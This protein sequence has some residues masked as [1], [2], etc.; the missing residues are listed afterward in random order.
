VLRLLF[1]SSG[2][3]GLNVNAAMGQKPIEVAIVGGGCAGIAA[4]FE[5]SRPKHQGKY[6]V[7]VYQQ[8]WRLGGKGASGRGPAG[9]IEEHGIHVWMGFYENSFRL[10]R[11][12]YSELNRNP[13]TCRFADWRDAFSPEPLVGAM[14]RSCRGTWV[15]WLAYFPPAPG[16]PGDMP[17]TDAVELAEYLVRIVGLIQALLISAQD[18]R[19]LPA[20][21]R[22]QVSGDRTS[23]ESVL[24]MLPSA[25]E[26]VRQ[27]KRV[28]AFGL[29]ATTSGLIEAVN[30]VEVMVKRVPGY[31]G[32]LGLRLV[33]TISESV[34]AQLHS[35]V[36]IDDEARRVWQMVDLALAVVFGIFRYRL[37][38]HPRG[39]DA[40]DDVDLVQ[41]LRLNGASEISLNSTIIRALY[42]L[43]FAYEQGDP[44]IPRLAAG[45]A[46]R[47]ALR[48]LFTYRG[49]MVW[50]LNAGMGDVVFAPFYQLLKRRG[51]TFQFFHRLRNVKLRINTGARERPYIESLEFDEQA[52]V[53]NGNDYQPLIDVR[54]VPSWPAKPDYAQLIDGEKLKDECWEFESHWE[55]RRIRAKTLRVMED[56]DCV[57]LAVGLGAIPYVCRELVEH[58][59]RWRAMITHCKTAATQAF[60][61]W[62][63][64]AIEDLAAFGTQTTITGFLQPFETCADMRQMITQENWTIRPLSAAYFCGVLPDQQLPPDPDDPQFLEKARQQVRRNAVRFLSRDLVH[65]WPAVHGEHGFR[66]NLLV[67]PLAVNEDGG[68]SDES[69]FDSQ[70]WTAN[71]NP[72]DRYCLSLPR[73]LQYRISPLDNTYDNLTV[74][75]DWTECGLNT[76]CVEAA[77]ISGRLAAHA[78][79]GCP[80]LHEIVGYDHP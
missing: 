26:I 69:R 5:L 7:T 56:F 3:K 27:I 49:S 14:D 71:V 64:Q 77:I 68:R 31:A 53:N 23:F 80:R 72:S 55:R 4:A 67:N 17:A 76:G 48:L 70:F 30:L 52:Q 6:H 65:L 18:S 21:H 10:L 40:I 12:C 33:R 36:A 78:I 24:E 60:Q 29:I 32:D 8:G 13:R 37:L 38:S 57:V 39:L 28:L 22:T 74:A 73:T 59:P 15:P 61:V 45:V 75:G 16:I 25:A 19:D 58:D 79:S 35:L 9:R 42:D 66:W 43:P 11:E 1:L 46:L 50:K 34:H 62:M 63:N 41:W 2:R 44:R 47:G 54:S 51:V 20:S